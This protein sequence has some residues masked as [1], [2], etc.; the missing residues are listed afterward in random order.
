M[1]GQ[2]VSSTVVPKGRALARYVRS[3]ILAQGDP[4]AAAAFA[5]SQRWAHSTPEVELGLKAA[6]SAIT[7]AE[8]AGSPTLSHP[9]ARDLADALRPLTLLGRLQGLRRVPHN[10]RLLHVASGTSGSWTGEGIPVPLGA[11]DFD[12]ASL[13]PLK[14]NALAVITAELA[15]SSAPSAEGAISRDVLAACAAAADATFID[16][17]NAGTASVKP[18]SVTSAGTSITSSGSSIAQIDSDLRDAVNVLDGADVDL[19]TA[20]WI[21][22]GRTAAFLSTLR[23][24]GGGLAYPGM[25][26]RGG[27]LLGLPALVS[28]GVP[29]DSNSPTE[30]SISLV[31]A[32]EVWL[33]DDG[34]AQIELSQQA[35]LQMDSAPAEG[36]QAMVSLWQAGLSAVK[37]TRF[38]NWKL[39][40][41]TG[42]AVI[43]GVDF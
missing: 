19:G 31:C 18:A 17:E 26:I 32:S 15:R 16:P 22:R 11:L 4:V 40:R 37:V 43:T 10:S 27:E 2:P 7:V 39:R 30:T 14:V 34:A 5:A 8:D 21:M 12:A 35:S 1:S 28:N 9:L 33:A 13:P 36:A 41:A 25:G 24:T 38:V 42:C 6:V 29:Y 23:G 20:A 3:L